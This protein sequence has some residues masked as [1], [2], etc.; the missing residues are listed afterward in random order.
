MHRIVCA[1]DILRPWQSGQFVEDVQ[2]VLAVGLSRI[3]AEVQ[4]VLVSRPRQT[5]ARSSDPGRIDQPVVLQEANEYTT[6]HPRRSHLRDVIRAPI[7]IALS[8]AFGCPGT[9][10]LASEY[11]F[12]WR[13]LLA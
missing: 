7:L 1:K 11:L 10:V 3:G 6:E 9:L 2:Q 13:H 5:L 8:S 12:D 4:F